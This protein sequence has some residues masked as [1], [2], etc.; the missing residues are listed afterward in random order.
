MSK[1]TP[2]G[3]HWCVAAAFAML[4]ALAVVA[5]AV[6]VYAE[7]NRIADRII[8]SPR[9]PL[10][11]EE[12]RAFVEGVLA[13]RIAP[14]SRRTALSSALLD[15]QRA[16]GGMVFIDLLFQRW[17]RSGEYDAMFGLA[18]NAIAAR[19]ENCGPL[20]TAIAA[21]RPAMARTIAQSLET[22]EGSDAVLLIALLSVADHETIIKH[23]DDVEASVSSGTMPAKAKL[24]IMRRMKN[25]LEGTVSDAEEGSQ[26]STNP[27]N[28]MPSLG[29]SDAEP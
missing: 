22:W 9:M 8:D 12:A 7:P 13:G 11:D 17:E 29:Q 28:G 4:A 6:W 2:K 10:S 20:L 26:A 21:V 18:G 25:A 15:R 1:V 5:V 27:T 24:S 19:R 16:D 3:A 23:R 14:E